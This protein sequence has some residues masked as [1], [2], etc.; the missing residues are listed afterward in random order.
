MKYV[1]IA[2][3]DSVDYEIHDS[4]IP[5]PELEDANK[6]LIVNEE[7]AYELKD[8]A[9][10]A[11]TK[12]ET[13][14]LLAAKADSDDVYDKDAIDAALST[15]QDVLVS[16]ENIKTINGESLLGNTDIELPTIADV[17]AKQDAL[18][19]GANVSILNNVVSAVDT[20]Y[21]AGNGLGLDGTEFVVDTTVIA[22]K[23]DLE[24]KL[25]IL[26]LLSDILF[27]P[28]RFVLK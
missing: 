6:A 24:A 19:A 10:D 13:D 16:G 25:T 23:G 14:V 28:C 2:Q 1:N 17:A 12:S 20:T 7:G 3:K 22:T 26:K 15:K 11:Y 21:S 5:Q 4:R 8:I 9:V 27:S 18:T